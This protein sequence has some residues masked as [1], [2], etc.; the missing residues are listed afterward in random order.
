M[1]GGTVAK[2]ATTPLRGYYDALHELKEYEQVVLAEAHA[3][4]PVLLLRRF[5]QSLHAFAA[6]IVGPFYATARA[7]LAEYLS[8]P[9]EINSTIKFAAQISDGVPRAVTP[10][11][12]LGF[13]YV[14]RELSPLRTRGENR[15]ARRSLDLLL[16]NAHDGLPIYAELKIGTDKPSY[17]ALVQLLA[18]AAD[19][20]PQSQRDRFEHHAGTSRLRWSEAGPF[21]D[22]YIIALNS[23]RTGAYRSRSFA[24]TE[25]IS[26]KLIADEKF[27]SQ[28][29]RVVYLEALTEGGRLAFHT[30]F[31]YGDGL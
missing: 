15:P 8:P 4:D 21:A 1:T 31:A 30:H 29:R 5:E 14:D 25:Q 23:P 2:S 9:G 28:I 24:A 26:Q 11:A 16:A 17:F 3:Q 13:R 6:P 10:D 7:D 19:F 20:L 12:A 27:S 18:L 22:L